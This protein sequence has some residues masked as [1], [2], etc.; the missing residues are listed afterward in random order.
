M[1]SP[2]HCCAAANVPEVITVAASNVAT[3]YN[4]TKAGEHQHCVCAAFLLPGAPCSLLPAQQPCV[5][6]RH[7]GSCCNVACWRRP[8]LTAGDAE[9]IYK[10]SNTGPCMD[11]FAPVGQPGAAAGRE[12]VLAEG[13][14]RGCWRRAAGGSA[15]SPT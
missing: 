12:G 9:D 4:G 2:C 3:K 11:L 1:P 5:A 14:G 7:I 8:S 13:G 6:S 15:A 10:W